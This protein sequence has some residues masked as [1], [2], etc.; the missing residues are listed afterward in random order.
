MNLHH[1][2]AFTAQ[3]D[4]GDFMLAPQLILNTDGAIRWRVPRCAVWAW[5]AT[6]ERGQE[7]AHACGIVGCESWTTSPRIEYEA[8]IQALS[9]A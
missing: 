1:H 6:N 9:W 4:A 5:I 7:L 8:V 3:L 2:Q